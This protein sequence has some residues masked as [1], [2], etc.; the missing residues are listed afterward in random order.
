MT[1]TSWYQVNTLFSL[2][3]TGIL[4]W[5]DLNNMIASLDLMQKNLE[6]TIDEET[7]LTAESTVDMANEIQEN[8]AH[9]LNI[10]K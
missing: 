3:Y 6:D 2:I 4:G 10:V 9:L 8:E 5:E 7:K 1:Y